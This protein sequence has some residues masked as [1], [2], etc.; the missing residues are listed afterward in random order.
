MGKP[1]VG[2]S[3]LKLKVTADSVSRKIG[4]EVAE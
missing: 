3:K 1:E 4:Y 2:S